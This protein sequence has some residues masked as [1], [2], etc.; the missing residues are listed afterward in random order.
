MSQFIKARL[1]MRRAMC[2]DAWQ[3]AGL[4]TAMNNQEPVTA[5]LERAAAD[6][7]QQTTGGT[8]VLAATDVFVCDAPGFQCLL[9]LPLL[10]DSKVMVVRFSHRFTHALSPHSAAG[11]TANMVAAQRAALAALRT[12]DQHPRVVLA[13][14]SAYDYMFMLHHTG[15]THAACL[16][17]PSHTPT[18][19][20][21]QSVA[22]Q[23]HCTYCT[24]WRTLRQKVQPCRQA[25]CAD[26]ILLAFLAQYDTLHRPHVS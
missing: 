24:C 18:P 19:H 16:F 21:A 17:V 6:K 20:S 11:C 14:A 22:Q 15:T 12:F 8:A 7:F 10:Q 1:R 3:E 5:Y 2:S 4:A 9:L 23:T 26:S 13:T 25:I